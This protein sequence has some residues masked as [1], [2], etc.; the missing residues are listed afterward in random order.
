MKIN[1]ASTQLTLLS[2]IDEVI[3]AIG[4]GRYAIGVFLAFSKAFDIFICI[5]PDRGVIII[6][7]CAELILVKIVYN[8]LGLFFGINFSM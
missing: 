5:V 2:F 1:M 8:I 7:Y 3:Q 6:Y 4:K